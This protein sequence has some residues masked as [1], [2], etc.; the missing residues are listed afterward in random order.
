MSTPRE[1]RIVGKSQVNQHDAS[2]DHSSSLS[3]DPSPQ[4][5]TATL[6]E[7][8]SLRVEIVDA[9]QA[10]RHIMQI[11]LTG[12]SVMIGLGLQRIDPLLAVIILTILV[13]T[14]TIFITTGA[15]GEFFRAARA[16]AFLAYRE[17]IIN[18]V[19]AGPVSAQEWERQLRHRRVFIM[20]DRVEFLAVFSLNT[21]S[22]ALGFYTMFT[23]TLR[24]EQPVFL[25][26]ALGAV[27]VVTRLLGNVPYGRASFGDY[28][29]QYRSS[30]TLFAFPRS[31]GGGTAR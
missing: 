7:Y 24:A 29:V 9:I 25:I 3:I 21:G 10:Q 8:K 18:S 12:L 1:G 20:R 2:H 23:S 13:P 5:V 22:L 31:G 16:S 6:E 15:L 30:R 17:G 19:V 26:V 11:G 28:Q 27:A 4:W 14:V